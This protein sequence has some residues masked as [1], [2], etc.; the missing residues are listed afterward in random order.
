MRP[1]SASPAPAPVSGS[2][3]RWWLPSAPAG[4]GLAQAVAAAQAQNRSAL[5]LYLPVCFPDRL[6]GRDALHLLAQAADVI[7]LGVPDPQ[8]VLAGPDIQEASRIALTAGFCMKDVFDAASELAATS[9]TA[10]LVTASW[11][12]IRDHG[13]A[14]FAAEATSVGICGVMIPD[15]PAHEENGWLKT[16]AGVGLA[17]IP[18][19]S[20][21]TRPDR[22]AAIVAGATGMVYAP[23]TDGPTGTA[24]PI[25]P[26]LP[27]L[28]AQ[29]RALTSLPIATGLGI[30]T[31]A[32]ARTAA[33][34]ADLVA[35]GSAVIRRMQARPRAQIA[36]AAAVSREFAAALRPDAQPDPDRGPR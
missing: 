27:D 13:L 12:P 22:L 10:L 1:D 28:S 35:V 6:T 31:P 8:A 20:P 36:A 26:Q 7:E 2:A 33:A 16:A 17:V 21:R 11:Q 18:F 9:S 3:W 14:E 30:S 34:S 24:Q 23:A 19:I 15:L 25:S 5:S 4:D 32:Q 29:L